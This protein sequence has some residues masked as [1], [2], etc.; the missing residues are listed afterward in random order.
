MIDPHNVA[1]LFFNAAARFPDNTAIIYRKEKVSYAEL[2]RDVL[3]TCAYFQQRGINKGDRVLVF[4]PMSIDLYRIVL[5]LFHIGATAV[6]LDEWVNVDRL[7]LCCKIAKCKAFIAPFKVRALS[8]LSPEL[9]KIPVMIGL[10]YKKGLSGLSISNTNPNETALITFT[11]GSTGTPKVAKRTHGFLRAQFDVLEEELR[12]APSDITM[13]TL[14]IVLLINLAAGSTSVIP[15]YN[16]KKGLEKD[17]TEVTKVLKKLNVNVILSS[18]AFVKAIGKHLLKFPDGDIHLKKVY[19][20]GA[21][22][23]PAD[24]K[25]YIE[26]FGRSTVNIIYGSTEAE[27]ISAASAEDLIYSDQEKGLYVGKPN[28]NIEV[29]IIKI[30]D[31]DI[32]D[33]ENVEQIILPEGQIGEIIVTGP[34]VLKE[35]FNNEAAF[36]SNKIAE[37]E[38]IWHRTGDSGYLENG[39]L[40]LTGRS[41]ELI[42]LNGELIA[43]FVL[44][45]KLKQI[46]GIRVG[47]IQLIDNRLF[48]IIEIEKGANQA[49][50]EMTVKKIHPSISEVLFVK[51]MPLDLRHRSKI[52]YEALRKLIGHN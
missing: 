36:R 2:E 31:E 46:D 20:G 32:P 33:I 10:N 18:P 12:P 1:D 47:T 44:E 42:N 41:K 21:P 26:A 38:T 34:H 48:I 39:Q 23:F 49:N 11:T 37:G 15:V 43:P 9:W 3:N 17:F 14:P 29:K 35:Y 25:M 4:V 19:T 22:V 16:A 5:S 30:T 8:W 28:I 52:D 40:Y 7:N 13:T 51:K 27:P 6:F 45:N 50:I 24:A